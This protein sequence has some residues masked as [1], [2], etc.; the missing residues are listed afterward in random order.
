MTTVEIPALNHERDE[1]LIGRSQAWLAQVGG[2]QIGNPTTTLT[3][4]K[5]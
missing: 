5:G 2:Q 3:P 1:L 4:T